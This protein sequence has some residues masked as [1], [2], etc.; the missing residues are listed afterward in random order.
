M[1]RK[2][3][4]KVAFNCV[5]ET[6]YF[7]QKEIWKVE[8]FCVTSKLISSI[9][10]TKEHPF[11]IE[12]LGFVPACLLKKGM[13]AISAS[14]QR[15]VICADAKV[16]MERK[17]VHNFS[18][19][20]HHSYFVDKLG[21]WV[22]NPC[23]IEMSGINSDAKNYQVSPLAR[24]TFATDLPETV[25]LGWYTKGEEL[26]YMRP[27]ANPR[28]YYQYGDPLL[29]FLGQKNSVTISTF[30]IKMNAVSLSEN[31]KLTHRVVALSNTSDNRWHLLEFGGTKRRAGF[32]DVSMQGKVF[33]SVIEEGNFTQMQE[34]YG[35]NLSG[36]REVSNVTALID[37]L[38]LYSNASYNPLTRNCQHFASDIYS[39]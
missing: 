10:T 12:G 24:Y 32:F 25:Q 28:E 26:R 18:V 19:Q 8:I 11:Y 3:S 29:H 35:F 38:K 1:K 22:H 39:L 7:A 14:G 31:H 6:F 33:H 21:V 17:A 34:R 30:D 5:E 16:Q 9:A 36:E 15:V 13:Y 37:V 4:Q 27:A 2:L 20:S 23:N